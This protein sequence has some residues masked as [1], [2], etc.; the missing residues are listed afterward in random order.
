MPALDLPNAHRLRLLGEAD[1]GEL[2]ALIEA[3]R[4]YLARWMA[5]AQGQTSQQ[6]LDFIRSAHRQMVGNDGF[7]LAIVDGEGRIA[8]VV[9]FTGVDW[10]N[11]ATGIGY[12]LAEA[13]Q[14]QGT[15]T[16]AVRS[17]LAHALEEW[18]LHRV[19]IRVEPENLRSR[20]VAQRLGFQQ[21]GTLRQVV[22]FGERYADHVVYAALAG[23]WPLSTAE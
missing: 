13:A 5:W 7:H 10:T 15:M 18:K 8:G 9:G 2:Q 6:T 12:W 4:T 11:R 1:A 21:E 3:N 16:A 23:E 17:L 19:E 22:R 14:G 20:A